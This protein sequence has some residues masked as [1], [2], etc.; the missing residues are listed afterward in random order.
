[1][2]S[3]ADDFLYSAHIKTVWY[4]YNVFLMQKGISPSHAVY[5]FPFIEVNKRP[6]NGS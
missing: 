6:E 2:R 3:T 4:I 1:M 5:N